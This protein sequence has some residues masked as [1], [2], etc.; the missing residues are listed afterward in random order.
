MIIKH[1][2]EWATKNIGKSYIVTKPVYFTGTTMP[3]YERGDSHILTGFL[4]TKEERVVLFEDKKGTEDSM[5]YW[6][7]KQTHCLRDERRRA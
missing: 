5:S 1:F 2:T 3:I 6:E 4:V 7:F